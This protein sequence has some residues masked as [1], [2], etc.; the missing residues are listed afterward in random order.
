MC[1]LISIY[2]QYAMNIIQSKPTEIALS[3]RPIMVAYS[4]T[5]ELSCLYLLSAFIQDFFWFCVY[6]PSTLQSRKHRTQKAKHTK[7]HTNAPSPQTQAHKATYKPK[8]SYYLIASS[9]E[10][11]FQ[12]RKSDL[13]RVCAWDGVESL[14]RTHESQQ[15]DTLLTWVWRI[16]T[17][18]ELDHRAPN[19]ATVFTIVYIEEKK[20]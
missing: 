2:N 6:I 19:M 1:T 15:E 11:A 13:H 10:Q 17:W 12:Q 9:S 8:Q 3:K 7:S 14:W 20:R 18:A 5:T 16:L 4:I